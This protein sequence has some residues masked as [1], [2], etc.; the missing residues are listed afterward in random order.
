MAQYYRIRKEWNDGKWDKTQKGAYSSK[1]QAIDNC[2]QDLIDQGYKVYDSNGEIVYPIYLDEIAVQ[3]G[4]DGVTSDVNYWSNVFSEKEE[5]NVEYIRSIIKR[6]Q[7]KLQDYKKASTGPVVEVVNHGDTKMYKVPTSLFRIAYF[8]KRKRSS[9]LDTIFNAG[10]FGGFDE[11]DVYF[12]LP[13]ANLVCDFDEKE[14][15]PVALKYLKERVIKNGK[16]YFSANKN[17][18]AQF[19]KSNVSTLVIR[20]GIATVE[21]LNSVEDDNIQYAISGAAIIKNGAMDKNYLSEGFD[22]SITRATIHTMI[23]LKDNYIYIFGYKSTTANCITSGEIYNAF[24]DVGFEHL[25]KLD[26]GG[27]AYGKVNREVIYN[28]AENRQVSNI[29]TF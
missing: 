15:S 27:S 10:Y 16:L 25:L 28:T 26:G 6:Y 8:D 20:N 29:I 3:M 21:L 11:G 19:R 7:A 5:M 12:T 23:G 18:S 13:S 9:S 14:V 24:A 2:S 22:N 17:S 4:K 1:D